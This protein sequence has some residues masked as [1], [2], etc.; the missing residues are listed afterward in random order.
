[1]PRKKPSLF[2]LLFLLVGQSVLG[3]ATVLL[4]ANGAGGFELPGGL[5]AN[6][7]TAVNGTQVHGW[8]SN[9]G[10]PGASGAR[11]AFMTTDYQ[12][13]NPS[14]GFNAAAPGASFSHFYRDISLPANAGNILLCF[15]F[16]SNHQVTNPGLNPPLRVYA[17]TTLAGSTFTPGSLPPPG[18]NPIYNGSAGVVPNWS[19]VCVQLSPALAGRTI[20]LA[21][22]SS[23]QATVNTAGPFG[24]QIDSISLVARSGGQ[25][26]TNL[27]PNG[28]WFDVDNWSGG[29]VPG[30]LDIVTVAAGTV[31]NT[32]STSTVHI[33]S[34]TIDGVLNIVRGLTSNDFIRVGALGSFVASS[35]T[36]NVRGNFI[37]SQ[38]GAVNMSAGVLAFVQESGAEAQVFSFHSN[39]QFSS[40]RVSALII[41]NPAGVTIPGSP[42]QLT[43]YSF[44][45]LTRGVFQHN[46]NILLNST[47]VS[48]T[49]APLQLAI[50]GGRLSAF[51]PV[52]S[53][54]RLELRYLLTVGVGLPD[55]VMTVGASN[56]L[57]PNR[58]ISRLT[59][60]NASIT[61]LVQD[62]LFLDDNII[63]TLW[64]F[65]TVKVAPG[66][67]IVLTNQTYPGGGGTSYLNQGHVQGT[68]VFTINGSNLA[69]RVFPVGS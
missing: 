9:T 42:G 48:A 25:N 21:F 34:I 15:K 23:I 59:V 33:G 66:K 50:A 27:K 56:E 49:A 16:R 8:A 36:V 67:A 5:A 39:T 43:V 28:D 29:Y 53:T 11:A 6:G 2:V 30:P 47:A 54:N 46:G 35:T 3:Q 17:D 51:P 4:D 41:N 26:L 52:S 19:V 57:P 58:I 40:G 55:T 31:L 12:Q 45:N 62:S 1:M 61:L 7:W 69:D 68:L 32:G 14:I 20:R 60:G 18:V 13:A 10:V 24:M 38:G 65:G 22:T 37:V 44:I 63:N 64:L